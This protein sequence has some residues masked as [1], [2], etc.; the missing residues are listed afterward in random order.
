[1]KTN[2]NVINIFINILHEKLF[3][4]LKTQQL[5]LYFNIK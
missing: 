4:K 2:N 5:E 3:V 1:M